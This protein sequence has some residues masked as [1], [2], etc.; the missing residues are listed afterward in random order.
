MR[1]S[2]DAADF[3]RA[4]GIVVR[5]A[6]KTTPI[7]I[8]KHARITASAGQLAVAATDMDLSV[9]VT[10]SAEVDADGVMVLPASNLAG[11]V[12]TLDG[13]I[14]IE[15]LDDYWFRVVGGTSDVKL[16]GLDPQDYPALPDFPE[17]LSKLPAAV[18]LPAIQRTLFIVEKRESST[19][20]FVR[21][22][23]AAGRLSVSATDGHRLAAS[24][25]DI[26]APDMDVW[27]QPAHAR[28]LLDVGGE[29]DIEIAAT[30]DRVFSVANGVRIAGM[31]PH[32]HPPSLDRALMVAKDFT[33]ATVPTPD[34]KSALSRISVMGRS[35]DRKAGVGVAIE[36]RKDA[37]ILK[38]SGPTGQIVET[39]KGSGKPGV[40]S[41]ELEYLTQ[42]LATVEADSITLCHGSD[43]ERHCQWWPADGK[44]SHRYLIAQRRM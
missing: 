3:T 34:L 39:L 41:F 5:V 25:A 18:L 44:D 24:F 6:E 2:V 30:E 17:E 15:Q 13:R 16:A 33:E 9:S 28:L 37:V 43:N 21:V 26:T 11:L 29:G 27:L 14:G 12:R 42:F 4:M 36:V 20:P 1:C 35:S 19:Y 10:L 38:T 8:L 22:L 32:G 7:E 31:R 40:M 23:V